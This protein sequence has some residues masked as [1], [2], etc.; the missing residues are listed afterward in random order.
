MKDKIHPN[1]LLGLLYTLKSEADN[2]E[3]R[4]AAVEKRLRN[5]GISDP[6]NTPRDVAEALG[7]RPSARARG[8]FVGT[9]CA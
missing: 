6:L 5:Q 1:S 4:I 2:L 9:H 7:R 8:M 3:A